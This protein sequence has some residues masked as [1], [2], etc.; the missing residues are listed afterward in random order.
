MGQKSVLPQS[1]VQAEDFGGLL[2][3]DRGVQTSHRPFP[4]EDQPSFFSRTMT[5]FLKQK[6]QKM[7]KIREFSTQT[8]RLDLKLRARPIK[9][10]RNMLCGC[11][12]KNNNKWLI[13]QNEEYFMDYEPLEELLKRTRKPP[14]LIVE[15]EKN[16]PKKSKILENKEQ[17]PEKESE[18]PAFLKGGALGFSEL[19]GFLNDIELIE[20]LF[21]SDFQHIYRGF[22][23]KR[24]IV[25]KIIELNRLEPRG[26]D[27]EE[28]VLRDS[29]KEGII[30][31]RV[32]S[33]EDEGICQ[34]LAQFA[35]PR[36]NTTPSNER[37]LEIIQISEYGRCSLG[38][39]LSQREIKGYGYI[40]SIIPSKIHREFYKE[41]E[42][43]KILIGLCQT[44]FL[45]HQSRVAHENLGPQNLLIADSLQGFRIAG[46]GEAK[47]IRKDGVVVRKANNINNKEYLAPELYENYPEA[48]RNSNYDPFQADVYSLGLIVLEMMGVRSPKER[49]LIRKGAG[50]DHKHLF[51]SLEKS[52]PFLTKIAAKMLEKTPE[53]RISLRELGKLLKTNM[54][55]EP[56]NVQKILLATKLLDQSNETN[57]LRQHQRALNE[58]VEDLRL[59]KMS[60]KAYGYFLLGDCERSIDVYKCLLTVTIQNTG[61]AYF[62]NPKVLELLEKIG[63]VCYYLRDYDTALKYFEESFEGR[64][65]KSMAVEAIA[66]SAF[67][68]ALTYYQLEQCHYSLLYLE[69]SLD[70][71]C[72][73]ELDV[74]LEI[75]RILSWKGL[76]LSRLTRHEESLKVFI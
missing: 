20:P 48:V 50:I 71:Y 65:N 55:K 27:F 47:L 44:L 30:Y 52:Y 28:A 58:G 29:L 16:I 42:L 63:T 70:F 60:F 61:K 67:N 3:V 10:R 53:S 54:P 12:R 7:G 4:G 43:I 17:I 59:D 22:W 6:P 68:L 34:L 19:V 74:R 2:L 40:L 51:D 37:V 39:L 75:A 38:E 5:R 33:I 62:S 73:S 66:A 45:A 13:L 31:E 36:K 72:Q 32:K 69:K 26:I 15:K 56:E 18:L 46:W 49:E 35:L 57:F 23:Q 64:Q 41:R 21:E 11:V 25:I 1:E 9:G 8:D 24:F 14:E 76:V